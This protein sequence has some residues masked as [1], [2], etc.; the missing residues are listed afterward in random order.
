MLV[1]GLIV[2]LFV[3]NHRSHNV[4]SNGHNFFQFLRLFIR[5]RPD[6]FHLVTITPVLFGL[7]AAYLAALKCV[8]VSV[9]A[10][11]FVFVHSVSRQQYDACC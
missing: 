5:V 11:E 6:V 3:L 1:L 4:F 10:L 9:F 2:H 8:V 7:V